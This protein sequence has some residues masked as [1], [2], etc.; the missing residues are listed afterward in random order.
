MTQKLILLDID[1]VLMPWDYIGKAR[2]PKEVTDELKTVSGFDDWKLVDK[3]YWTAYSAE[4]HA[5]IQE[6]GQV[7][8]LTTWA[9]HPDMLDD[10]TYTT[11]FGPFE[12]ATGA[13]PGGFR[14]WWKT[15][16]ALS[17]AE[18]DNPLWEGVEEVIWVD[19]DHGFG[20]PVQAEVDAVT[21]AIERRHGAKTRIIRP[22]VVWT[23]ESLE[24]L[25]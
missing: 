1:G 3:P 18:S 13:E 14:Y 12:V 22:E 16:W 11:G 2:G 5:L 8:W 6:V 23:R 25:L 15:G 4:Q 24:Q 7:V 20:E 17:F 21:E 19:D 10:Y 9:R